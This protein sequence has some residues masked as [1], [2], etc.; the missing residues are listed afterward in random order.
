MVPL[1]EED[2]AAGVL[3]ED[4]VRAPGEED[5]HPGECR[6]ALA[7]VGSPH[8]TKPSQTSSSLVASLLDP[9]ET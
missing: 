1:V 3:E 2:E 5:C 8:R 9:P 6:G 7:G 4:L